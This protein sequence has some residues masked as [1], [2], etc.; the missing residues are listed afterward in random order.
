MF[1]VYQ[2]TEKL[3]L[4][5]HLLFLLYLK[6]HLEKPSLQPLPKPQLK[7]YGP[8][9]C[10]VLPDILRTKVAVYVISTNFR[11]FFFFLKFLQELSELLFF[12]FASHPII[13]KHLCTK[14]T[15]ITFRMLIKQLFIFHV[16]IKQFT[17]HTTLDTYSNHTKWNWHSEGKLRIQ[18]FTGVWE[19]PAC[20]YGVRSI[21]L[22]KW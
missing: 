14:Y 8:L 1:A 15:L 16:L 13:L 7:I 3:W 20:V 12:S 6:Q 19:I 21:Q 18:C 17:T 10:M 22:D 11:F 9:C 2:R 5:D 4:S